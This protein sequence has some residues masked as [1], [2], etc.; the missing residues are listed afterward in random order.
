MHCTNGTFRFIFWDQLPSDSCDRGT[1][2]PFHIDAL[3][4]NSRPRMARVIDRLAMT[5][6]RDRE[7]RSLL[8]NAAPTQVQPL[9]VRCCCSDALDPIPLVHARAAAAVAQSAG[10]TAVTSILYG[11]QD[12]ARRSQV[13]L[14]SQWRASRQRRRRR[15]PVPPTPSCVIRFLS[16]ALFDR[17]PFILHISIVKRHSSHIIKSARF[18]RSI[19]SA[20]VLNMQTCGLKARWRHHPARAGSRLAG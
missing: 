14:L 10:R 20:S 15:A 3:F 11:I 2:H 9:R 12:C 5:C 7:G 6:T 13:V 16:P 19:G 1:I 4:S 8:S 18:G 17:S